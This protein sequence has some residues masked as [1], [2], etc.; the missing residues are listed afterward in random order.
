VP[1]SLHGPEL[2]LVSDRQPEYGA[3]L[4]QG[5]VAARGCYSLNSR[6]RRLWARRLESGGIGSMVGK[7]RVFV[8]WLRE[9][10]RGVGG[11]SGSELGLPR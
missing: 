6:K 8:A 2:A 11:L 9:K 3:P 1:I 10:T 4:R 7:P 5:A